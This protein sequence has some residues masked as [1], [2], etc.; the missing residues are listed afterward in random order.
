MRRNSVISLM[1]FAT[2][3]FAV[4][5][6]HFG[7]PSDDAIANNIKALLFSDPSL[8]SANIN[9]TAKDG[10]VT[11]S[12]EVPDDAARLAAEK[13]ASD[14][15]GVTKVNDQIV[16]TT[17]SAAPATP[18]AVAENAPAAEPPQPAPRPKRSTKSSRVKP[19]QEAQSPAP[20]A[21]IETAQNAPAPAAAAVPVTPP[22]PPPP[23]RPRTVTLP[24]GAILTVRTIDRIDSRTNHAGE[25][26]HASLDAPIVVNNEVIVPS[27]ADAYI[28][29]ANASSAGR[30]AGRNEL[31]LE[32]AS[33]SFR[34]RTYNV[35]SSDVRQAGSSRGKGS[36]EKIGGGAAIGALIGAVAGGGKGAA[37][38]AAVGGGAGAGLQG[39]RKGKDLTIPSETRLD[40][41]LQAPLD[42]TY[43]PGKRSRSAE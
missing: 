2:L 33:V 4:S 41:T 14:V 5:C 16:A 37:I 43:V 10:V 24:A 3:T 40:F 21:P 17:A 25:I 7:R 8:K 12:G 35:V 42:I 38:G 36:A 22:P 29:L 11:L 23:P 32:L 26:F 18:P 15:K 31:T 13:L 39:L 20:A 1:L 28:K 6:S 27:G 34:G 19:A 30:F 9:V